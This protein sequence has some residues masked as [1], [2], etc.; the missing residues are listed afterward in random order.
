MSAEWQ[1]LRGRKAD[2][3][4]AEVEAPS[5]QLWAAL[6]Q[7]AQSLVLTGQWKGGALVSIEDAVLGMPQEIDV[8]KHF[9]WLKPVCETYPDKTPSGYFLADVFWML[10]IRTGEKLL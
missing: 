2:W 10:H 5:D 1:S 4:K 6:P 8:T 7:E 9:R 3:A